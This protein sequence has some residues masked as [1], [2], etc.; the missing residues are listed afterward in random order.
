MCPIFEQNSYLTISN[1]PFPT[2]GWRRHDVQHGC[3]ILVTARVPSHKNT[4]VSTHV[5]P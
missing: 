4:F 1:G 3:E 2:A 5:D